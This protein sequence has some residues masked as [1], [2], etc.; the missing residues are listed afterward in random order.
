MKIPEKQWIKKVDA[1][2]ILVMRRCLRNYLLIFFGLTSTTGV[3]HLLAPTIH[4]ES[5]VTLTS[6]LC[7][8]KIL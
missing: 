5:L 1:A 6:A 3:V 2:T 7:K 8:S 4:V